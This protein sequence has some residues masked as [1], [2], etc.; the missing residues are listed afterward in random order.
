MP[1]NNTSKPGIKTTEFWVSALIPIIVPV[2]MTIANKYGFPLSETAV[3]A[4]V[5]G[6]VTPPVTYI[7]GRIYGKAKQQNQGET[8]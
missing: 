2:I 1:D 8:K 3:D 6:V 7:L 5:I 4:I